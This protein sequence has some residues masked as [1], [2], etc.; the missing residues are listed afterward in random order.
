MRLTTS[1]VLT[2]LVILSVI[3]S[4]IGCSKL[5]DEASKALTLPPCA[6]CR[7]LTNSFKKGMEKTDRGKFGGG[8]S[9]WEEQKLGAYANS[10]IRFIEIQEN[11]CKEV[12]HGQTQC[13]TLA[14][15]FETDIEEWWFKHQDIYPDIHIYICVEKAQRCCPKHHYGPNCTACPGYPDNVCSNNGKCKGAGT[16]KGKGTCTCDKG[17]GGD[18][19]SECAIGYYQSYKNEKTLLCSKC[20]SACEGSCKG[21]GPSN[22]ERC[23]CGWHMT[24]DKHTCVDINECLRDDVC[25]ENQFCVNLEGSYTCLACDKSCNGCNGDGPDM[26]IACA[27]GFHKVDKLCINTEF[28]GRKKFEHLFRYMTYLGL[29][30]AT[31]IIFQRDIYVA[32]I[33]GLLVAFYISVSEYIIATRGIENTIANMDVEA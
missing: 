30:V 8:D 3:M 19:C 28:F 10:Q 20:N 11:L 21:P 16:R 14:E 23:R 29:C 12:E 5:D 1:T 13:Q 2:F 31:Y 9:A 6:A 26:C 18:L 33:I 4:S 24:E 25:T 27:E 22:C 32:T 15:E 17:Y 7:L